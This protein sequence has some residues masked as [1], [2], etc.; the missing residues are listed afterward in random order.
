[1]SR[2][3][4]LFAHPSLQ[5]SRIHTRLLGGVSGVPGV[6]L[7]DL[8]QL[9]PEFDVDV[10][11]EQGLLA[12]HDVVIWQHPFYWYSVPPLLKQWIDLVLEHGWAYGSGG[13]ALHGKDL[14]SVISAGG[15]SEAYRAGG[16]N[17]F[18]FRE[19]L[20]PLEQT[21]ALCGMRYL[22]PWVVSG[23]HRIP[24]EGLQALAP[25]YRAL[26]EWLTRDGHRTVEDDGS[27]LMDVSQI[28]RG[29]PT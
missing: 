15:P 14:L 10:E 1:M 24:D 16:Y 13:T 23:T 25:S 29:V 27:S 28:P 5:T 9:Y 4:I 8:Y 12:S 2:V 6:T 22:P 21:A 19:F 3:L 20:R 7:R 18:T 11:A 17:R 26:L